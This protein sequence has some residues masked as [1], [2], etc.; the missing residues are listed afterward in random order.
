MAE[1]GGEERK[2]GTKNG[3]NSFYLGNCEVTFKF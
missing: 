2:Q 3:R 1:K